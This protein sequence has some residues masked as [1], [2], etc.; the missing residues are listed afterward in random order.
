MQ[1][2]TTSTNQIQ[3][4]L[5]A[6]PGLLGEEPLPEQESFHVVHCMQCALQFQVEVDGLDGGIGIDE[7]KE[8]KLHITHIQQST[9]PFPGSE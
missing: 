8:E 2:R 3:H 9:E 7:G 6:H 4:L 5:T 1:I